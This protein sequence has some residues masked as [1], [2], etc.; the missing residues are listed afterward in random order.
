MYLQSQAEKY[1]AMQSLRE[2]E[3]RLAKR[4]SEM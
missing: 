1:E 3:E 2:F 4:E